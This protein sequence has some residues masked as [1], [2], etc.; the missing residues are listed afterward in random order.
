MT[1][2][3]ARILRPLALLCPSRPRPT[4]RERQRRAYLLEAAQAVFEAHGRAPITLKAFADATGVSPSTIQR[5]FADLHHL[6]A[7][8]LT[9]HLDTILEAIGQI[10]LGAP[11]S[12]ARR[13]AAYRRA[14]ANPDATQSRLHILYCRDRFLLPP[15]QLEPLEQQRR[16]IGQLVGL[17]DGE[18]TLALLDCPTTS[19]R[20]IETML[21]SGQTAPAPQAI[22]PA[23]QAI[24]P[25]PQAI[26]PAPQ[27][28]TPAAQAITPAPQTAVTTP[29]PAHPPSPPR[30]SLPLPGLP[31]P[32]APP[33]PVFASHPMAPKPPPSPAAS[34]PH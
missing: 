14:A 9:R 28:I 26:T 20:Q 18:A 12:L 27:A 31:T 2:T 22:T 5:D 15:D 3:P 25:A 16:T 34:P 10:P 21:A 29:T 32:D 7:L 4:E 19:L 24:T 11:G 13:R 30:Q 17:Q 6:F 33:I 1:P 23:P 8:I